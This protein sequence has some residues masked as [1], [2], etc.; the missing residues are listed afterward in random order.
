MRPFITIYNVTT[1]RQDLNLIYNF[2]SEM[3]ELPSGLAAINHKEPLEAFT[4]SWITKADGDP[5][6]DESGD[7]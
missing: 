2:S 4:G 7:R 6:A 1:K 5:T 3:N